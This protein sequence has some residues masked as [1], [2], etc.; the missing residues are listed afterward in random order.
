MFVRLFFVIAASA[1][2]AAGLLMVRQQQLETMH[3]TAKL[4]DQIRRSREATWDL[5]VRIAQRAEPV[6]LRDTLSRS[7]LALE[8]TTPVDAEVRESVRLVQGDP[9]DE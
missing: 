1:A 7:E 3:E 4:Y 5:Q 9:R 8:P 2:I 6:E